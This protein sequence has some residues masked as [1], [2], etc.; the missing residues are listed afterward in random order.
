MKRVEELNKTK[1][2]KK[3]NKNK[4]TPEK[5]LRQQYGDYQ[6]ERGWWEVEEGKGV[7][8]GDGRRHNL[9]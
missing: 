5:T 8:N 4:K 1:Q 6:R 3:Q 2:Q 9:S 7:I